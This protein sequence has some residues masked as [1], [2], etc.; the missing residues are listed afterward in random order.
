MAAKCTACLI[1]LSEGDRKVHYQ[2][3]LHRYNLR[4]QVNAQP[5]VNQAQLDRKK[6]LLESAGY[7]V[8]GTAHLKN[9]GSGAPTVVAKTDG[10]LPTEFQDEEQMMQ[11]LKGVNRSHPSEGIDSPPA[12]V[13]RQTAPTASSPAADGSP[14]SPPAGPPPFNPKMCLFDNT[15]HDSMESNVKYMKEKF[16]FNILDREYLCDLE[17]LLRYLGTKVFEWNQCVFCNR[18]FRTFGGVRLHMID[19]GHTMLGTENGMDTEYESFYD[20]TSSIHAIP[21]LKLLKE[22]QPSNRSA[23][24]EAR[25]MNDD[26]GDD[27]EWED[28]EDEAPQVKTALHSEAYSL[29]TIESAFAR[30]GLKPMKILDGGSLRLPDG[31]QAGHRNM[32]Y[33]YR[34]RLGPTTSLAM[35]NEVRSSQ[36]RNLMA[37]KHGHLEFG[38]ADKKAIKIARLARMQQHRNN[39]YH[40]VRLGVKSNNLE[41]IVPRLLL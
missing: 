7:K 27:D 23:A 28:D 29:E 21:G 40:R 41:R 32:A 16:G 17:G 36:M 19:K 14:R 2:S 26:D 22:T 24:F 35:A 33:V 6:Q 20:F 3:E 37:A 34:Q 18:C 39:A 9:P 10:P 30:Y 31:R 5:P 12:P 15:E 8:K 1:D 11:G 25:Q 4:R 13:G 38:T